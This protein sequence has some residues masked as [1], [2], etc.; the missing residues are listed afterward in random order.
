MLMNIMLMKEHHKKL[1]LAGET[2]K[3]PSIEMGKN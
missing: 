2:L 3:V 1:F